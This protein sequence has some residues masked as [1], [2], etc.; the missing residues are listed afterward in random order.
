MSNTVSFII[1]LLVGW[2]IEW[3]IDWVYW[4]KKYASCQELQQKYALLE[5]QNER[6]KA[7]LISCRESKVAENVQKDKLQV[8]H[9]IGPVIERKLN[10]EGIF[11]YQQL[12]DL[13]ASQLEAILGEDIKN[14]V[15]E[16]SLIQEAKKLAQS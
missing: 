4:R 1:G 5:E 6:L 16:E 14:L 15:D 2:I 10:S 11:T 3:I 13:D 7:E 9:G 12:A 8:I